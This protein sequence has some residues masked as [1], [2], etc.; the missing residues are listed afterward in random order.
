MEYLLEGRLNDN[1][2]FRFG[3]ERQPIGGQFLT[4]SFIYDGNGQLA[5][6]NQGSNGAQYQV[7][8]IR[9][10]DAN[11]AQGACLDAPSPEPMTVT[12]DTRT[13]YENSLPSTGTHPQSREGEFHEFTITIP[14]EHPLLD[15]SPAPDVALKAVIP[16]LDETTND[17]FV[18]HVSLEWSAGVSS[19]DGDPAFFRWQWKE[20]KAQAS[21]TGFA[22][23]L[24]PHGARYPFDYGSILELAY[25]DQNHWFM[26]Q[27]DYSGEAAPLIFRKF[28]PP[29]WGNWAHRQLEAQ[30]KMLAGPGKYPLWNVVFTTRLADALDVWNKC[31][32]DPLR[33]SIE[34]ISG[35]DPVSFTPRFRIASVNTTASYLLSF[36]IIRSGPDHTT[37][38]WEGASLPAAVPEVKADF[39]RFL[40]EYAGTPTYLSGAF[41][42]GSST[43]LPGDGFLHFEPV[44]FTVTDSSGPPS[45]FSVLDGSIRF[46][47]GGSFQGALANSPQSL[48]V[49]LVFG[50]AFRS[51]NVNQHIQQWPAETGPANIF[52]ELTIGNLCF[53]MISASAAGQDPVTGEYTTLPGAADPTTLDAL[54]GR[55]GAVAV[56][57]TAAAAAAQ[58]LQAVTLALSV[59]ESSCPTQGHSYTMS[60]LGLEGKGMLNI[61]PVLMLDPEP[62]QVALVWPDEDSPSNAADGAQEVLAVRKS[63]SGSAWGFGTISSEFALVLPPS[64]VGEAMEK[65]AGG[66]DIAQGQQVDMRLAAPAIA[67]MLVTTL[68]MQYIEPPWNLRRLLGLNADTAGLPLEQLDFELIYGL[69]CQ[70]NFSPLMLADLFARVGFPASVIDQL[71]FKGTPDQETAFNL[72]INAQVAR[73]LGFRR[74]LGVLEVYEDG[75]DD[76]LL[77]TAPDAASDAVLWQP[78]VQPS[79]TLPHPGAQL[80][81]PLLGENVQSDPNLLNIKNRYHGNDNGDQK[82]LAGGFHWAFESAEIYK[83]FWA[84]SRSSSG[85]LREVY[86]SALG[87][88]GRQTARFSKDKTIIQGRTAAGRL[89]YYTLERI[90]RIAVFWN[91]AKHVIVYERT[92]G[93]SDQFAADQDNHAGRPILRKIKEYIEI[94]EQNR[95]TQDFAESDPVSA[96]FV[97]GTTFHDRI[98]PVYGGWGSDLVIQGDSTG[99]FT[100][101][102]IPLWQPGADP[103]IY[104]KPQIVLHVATDPATG[105]SSAPVVIENPDQLYF[106]TDTDFYA[107]ADTDTWPS[108]PTVDYPDLPEP[109]VPSVPNSPQAGPLPNPPAKHPGLNRFTFEVGESAQQV[110]LVHERVAD[111]SL[112]AVLRNVSM[113]RSTPGSLPPQAPVAPPHPT[114]DQVAKAAAAAE[115]FAARTS[116]L[117]AVNNCVNGFQAAT[118]LV[119]GQSGFTVAGLTGAVKQDLNSW[120]PITANLSSLA[121]KI[122]ATYDETFCTPSE[123]CGG[124]L[125]ILAWNQAVGR[126]SDFY[127]QVTGTTGPLQ[128]DTQQFLASIATYT[129]QDWQNANRLANEV[130]RLV[131]G[132]NNDWELF[133]TGAISGFEQ[134]VS[135]LDNLLSTA[136]DDFD[137]FIDDLMELPRQIDQ[138]N[139]IAQGDLNNLQIEIAAADARANTA[140]D[141]LT[142]QINVIGSVLGL[143]DVTP[144]IKP[145][146]DA[147]KSLHDGLQALALSSPPPAMSQLHAARMSAEQ[148]AATLQGLIATQASALHQKSQDALGSVR[149]GFNDTTDTVGSELKGFAARFDTLKNLTATAP[150]ACVAELNA[151]VARILGTIYADLK[152]FLC[153]NVLNGTVIP[154]IRVLCNPHVGLPSLGSLIEA[155]GDF[156]QQFLD[157][158][159]PY[160]RILDLANSLTGSAAVA[161]RA[162]TDELRSLG[163]DAG[164]ELQRLAQPVADFA[165]QTIRNAAND[166]ISGVCDAFNYASYLGQSASRT[167]RAARAFA[168]AL[169]APGLAFNRQSLTY[170][171]THGGSGLG[172]TPCVARLKELGQSLE[173]LGLNLPTSGLL[174]RL[175]PDPL[176]NFDLSDIISDIGGLRITDLFPSLQMPEISSDAIRVTHGID[177]ETLRAWVT[178]T[179]NLPLDG[180]CVLFSLGPVEVSVNSP[181]FTAQVTLSSTPNGVSKSSL[182]ILSGTWQLTFAGAEIMA[183][184]NTNLR[185]EDGQMHFDLKPSQVQLA[186]LL[187]MISS[188]LP[189]TDGSDDDDSDDDDDEE[190]FHLGILKVGGIPSG[191][192]ATLLLP[193]IDAGGGTTSIS[194]LQLGAFFELSFL[195]EISGNPVFE[196]ILKTGLNVGRPDKPFNIAIYILGGG[197][198]L[199]VSVEYHPLSRAFKIS[200]QIG[201]DVSATI[202]FAL[203]P[204]DGGVGIYLGMFLK[205][206]HESGPSAG[207]GSLTIGISFLIEGNASVLGIVEVSLSIL[208]EACYTPGGGLVGTG[209]VHVEVSICWCFSISVDASVSY[210]FGGP[211]G[212]GQSLDSTSGNAAALAS[213]QAST[214][215]DSYDTSAADYAD[216][217]Q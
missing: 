65:A 74:R 168:D 48:D 45:I 106:Y 132:L 202:E 209:T 187:Q 53:P 156:A 197:G 158:F 93:P 5:G 155:G 189:S 69:T 28:F 216:L 44:N 162:L 146:R 148:A 198:Y 159:P 141:A 165:A 13:P 105:A 193:E 84:D 196:F 96:G 213:P 64:V 136:S 55:P 39:F 169:I 63:G 46:D 57:V 73:M 56:P 147:W 7:D 194:G 205:Y 60:I 177:R 51:A 150:V 24:A 16:Q 102:Q 170:L 118:N 58:T 161:K 211:S 33:A 203:G 99:Q 50:A 164:N 182:G 140:L 116:L 26:F 101:W 86:L 172:M 62:F 97:L 137:G 30:I 34:L 175:V 190:G 181:T 36:Q 201:M 113:M 94:L 163:E 180:R 109:E 25:D 134:L 200:A 185:F 27:G 127:N 139:V 183:F 142:G 49:A 151:E 83:E 85:E 95:S 29:N 80:L 88:W 37:V 76:P 20:L 160:Q 77:I 145:I 91:R 133:E 112:N 167:L 22:G 119:N 35:E 131:N 9:I 130:D 31:M 89:H 125:H 59:V 4:R 215:A 126:A 122:P 70:V 8:R 157:N 38:N 184:V 61:G 153:N 42:F 179:M 115:A 3:I 78:R 41:D 208:L 17:G 32:A 149:D 100:G 186:S 81:F 117:A 19:G 12:F 173:A 104:P 176:Q 188:L 68:P 92:T 217:V 152:T 72:F 124:P 210:T 110:N 129:T 66:I 2:V 15:Q 23:S 114:A 18:Y 40:G 54:N 108:I 43:P 90:G 14:F 98:I 212:G 166:A 6:G 71:P 154:A 135:Q 143:P 107:S 67:R 1:V 199:V 128:T 138:A 21:I 214:T 178:A 204:I 111:H 195:Q 47:L 121:G 103:A 144:A 82:A 79:D 120:L 10:L 192:R 207:S 174:D 206:V 11:Q 191:M 171:L 52:L 75:T 123:T 87:A